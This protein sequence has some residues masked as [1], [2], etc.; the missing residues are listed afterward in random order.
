MKA[1][2]EGHNISNCSVTFNATNALFYTC[3]YVTR[4]DAHVLCRRNV[5]AWAEASRSYLHHAPLRQRSAS[6]W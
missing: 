4:L 6:G 5:E 3:Q 1:M 2:W